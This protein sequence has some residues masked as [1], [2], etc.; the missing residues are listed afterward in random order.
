MGDV[1]LAVGWYRF[2][3]SRGWKIPETVVPQDHCSGKY[4][5]WLNGPHPNVGEGE[6]TR[7][8]C[9]TLG[10][11]TCFGSRGINVKNCSG[12]FVYW[13]GP[14]P[15]SYAVYCTDSQSDKTWEPQG[16]A[17]DQPEP[18]LTTPA[19][20]PS[21]R[22]NTTQEPQGSATRESGPGLTTTPPGSVN[23]DLEASTMDQPNGSSTGQ[24]TPSPSSVSA[25]ERS[26]DSDRRTSPDAG[27]EKPTD[28]ICKASEMIPVNGLLS[29]ECEE[30]ISSVQVLYL[31]Q[32]N[33][34]DPQE[35]EAY[36]NQIRE[37]LREQL[38]CKHILSKSKRDKGNN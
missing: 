15:W 24:P 8:V 18:D 16:S 13:L 6:V 4:P 14:T 2:N 36:L 11:N 19:G 30:M 7:T 31:G 25:G 1:N 17:T 29:D 9:F 21:L 32:N 5:G 22:T 35:R 27:Q 38:P 33:L 3:S 20:S 37:I 10:E 23:S 26:S 12:Y 34:G 28:A